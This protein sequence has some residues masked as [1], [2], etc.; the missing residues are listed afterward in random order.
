VISLECIG[1]VP[2][3]DRLSQ[4]ER[5]ALMAAIRGRDTGPELAV[6]RALRSLG[7]GYRL[8]VKGLPGRP[9]IVMKGRGTVIFVHGCFWHRHSCRA[10]S[11]PKSRVDYWQAKFTGNIARDKR[12]QQQLGDA[13][14]TVLVIW[15]C[16]T[17]DAAALAKRLDRLLLAG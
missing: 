6:R 9:D 16:E 4:A 7:V 12:N 3:A 11:T 1:A 13:G 14:W 8:H 17:K 5:S 15:E 2:I 10:A